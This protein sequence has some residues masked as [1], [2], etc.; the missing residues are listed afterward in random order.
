MQAVSNKHKSLLISILIPII[1]FA[2]LG[3]TMQTVSA[4][5]NERSVSPTLPTVYYVIS[6]YNNNL[7]EVDILTGNYL[8]TRTMTLVG[9][10]TINGSNGLALH[11]Q[12]G[13]AYAIIKIGGQT[14]REL[15]TLDLLTG[16]AT[17]VGNTGE[18]LAGIT[19]A[20]DGTLFAVSGDGGTCSECLYSLNTSDGTA[21][22]LASLGNGTDGE[23]IAFNPD[24]GFIYHASGRDTNPAFEKI[25]PTAPYT[26]TPI[27]RTGFNYDEV[28]GLVY[29][30]NGIFL[31]FNVD[32]EIVEI[33]ATGVATNTGVTTTDFHKGA[34]ASDS[35]NCGLSNGQT[36]GFN[37]SSLPVTVTINTVGDIHCLQILRVMGNHP[38]ATSNMTD[39]Y[40][41]TIT[42]TTFA[43]NPISTYDV[44]LTVPHLSGLNPKLCRYPGGMGGFGWDCTGTQVDNGTTVTRQ[45]ITEFSDWLVGYDVGPTAVR[46]QS[47]G[48]SSERVPVTVIFISF[49]LLL[50]TLGFGHRIKRNDL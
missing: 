18:N 17:R 43:G 24:D 40:Y 47:N 32:N 49:V 33:A 36:V 15:V 42:G 25:E 19:F 22:F 45:N 34:I 21:T 44:D 50:I 35:A 37:Q 3:S 12:T 28:F 16:V 11:P 7:Y 1:L 6:P 2:F 23:S 29:H 20:A 26:I 39:G 46:L 4:T 31:A 27:V 38:A 5:R 9:G 41:W 48:T 13:V 14:G 10:G 8:V 30:G